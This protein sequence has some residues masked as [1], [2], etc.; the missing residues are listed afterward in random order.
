MTLEPA[1]LPGKRRERHMQ[2]KRIR[3]A[4]V[5]YNIVVAEHDAAAREAA[6]DRGYSRHSQR[7]IVK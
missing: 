4:R 5:R 6:S 3:R 2:A 1:H 7:A